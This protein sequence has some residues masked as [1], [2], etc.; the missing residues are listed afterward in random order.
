M[1]KVQVN[2]VVELYFKGYTLERALKIVKGEIKKEVLE[3]TLKSY[4]SRRLNVL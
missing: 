3:K 1:S 2:A 4:E